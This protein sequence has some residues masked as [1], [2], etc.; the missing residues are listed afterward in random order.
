MTW[1]ASFYYVFLYL[2]CFVVRT[3]VIFISVGWMLMVYASST[4]YLLTRLQK[5]FSICEPKKKGPHAGP[6]NNH[7]RQIELFHL[8]W[9]IC[10]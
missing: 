7:G 5:T 3:Y 4:T 6:H 10:G 8:K 2:A 9:F 1:T